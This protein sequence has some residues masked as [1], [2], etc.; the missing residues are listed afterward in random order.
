M[1]AHLGEHGIGLEA[2]VEDEHH[3]AL[4]LWLRLLATS[5]QVQIAIR[6]RLRER[7]GISL[8]RFDYL[9]QVH[10]HAEGLRMSVLTKHLMVTGGSVTGLTDELER[11]GWVAREADPDDRRS[12]RVRLTP[13]GR[14]NFER[15]AAE[16]E[17]W[18]IEL[19][20]TLS[21]AQKNELHE[22]LGR[23]RLHVASLDPATH[24]EKHA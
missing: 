14:R 18:V 11:E 12:V 6:N 8:A 21:A 4:K 5:T 10:R 23:L 1:H 19:F 9:A 3:Q 20:G 16:H 24:Q 7:F 15:M 13:T 22:Q 17:A 2:R